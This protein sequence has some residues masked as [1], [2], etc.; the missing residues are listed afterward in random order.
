[1]WTDGSPSNPDRFPPIPAY[2]I[3]AGETEY[4]HGYDLGRA[5]ALD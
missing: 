4:E 1:M 3:P 2:A 5:A